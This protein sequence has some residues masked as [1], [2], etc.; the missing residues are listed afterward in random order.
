[1]G[2]PDLIW[3]KALRGELGI[4]D[5]EGILGLDLSLHSAPNFEISPAALLTTSVQMS[6]GSDFSRDR[7]MH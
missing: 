5:E 7:C 3:L 6:A 2:S 4:P 1:M